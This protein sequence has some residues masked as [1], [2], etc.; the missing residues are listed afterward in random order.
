MFRTE[1]WTPP[2]AKMSQTNM[3]LGFFQE[4]EVTKRIYMQESSGYNVVASDAP[5]VHISGVAVF[6]RAVEHFSMELLQVYGENVFSYQLASVG[7]RWFIM[8]C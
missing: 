7:R 8:G 4:T 1:D 2:C 3:D 6:Y 5:R